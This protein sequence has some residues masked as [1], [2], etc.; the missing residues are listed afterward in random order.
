MK[1]RLRPL[2]SVS[3]LVSMWLLGSCMKKSESY[4]LENVVLRETN[5]ILEYLKDQKADSG[6]LVHPSGLVY[7]IVQ[8]GLG[9]TARIQAHQIPLL[10]FEN[11]QMGA[12]ALVQSSNNLP[13]DF[14]RRKL[15]DHIM[16]WQIALPLISKGGKMLL[17]IP[18]ALAYG[19]MG[20]PGFIAPNTILE[21]ELELI[22]F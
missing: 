4:D 12:Q 15:K 21:S 9:D 3:I 8:A 16:G 5:T 20:V 14:D 2:A 22:D 18:S 6:F 13:T 7:K 17:Y 1:R 11:R 19:S 10:R